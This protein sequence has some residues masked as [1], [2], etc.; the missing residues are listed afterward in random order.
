MFIVYSHIFRVWYPMH[1]SLISNSLMT[2]FN[3]IC[4]S[5]SN[6]Y[7][8]DI[9]LWIPILK[10]E[11]LCSL[12]FA[13]RLLYSSTCDSNSWACAFFLGCVDST[14]VMD[15]AKHA[16]LPTTKPLNNRFTYQMLKRDNIKCYLDWLHIHIFELLVY[17]EFSFNMEQINSIFL[18][19][20]IL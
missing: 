1:N 14:N 18:K 5:L 9:M 2:M 20:W 17:D 3:C 7:S 19:K 15:S 4:L 16:R 12:R 11:R 8:I 6:F 13:W 10:E